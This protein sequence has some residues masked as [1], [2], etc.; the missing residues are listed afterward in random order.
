VRKTTLL[1]IPPEEQAQ[2]LAVLRRVRYGS[3]L[4]LHVLLLCA[5]GRT[6]TEIAA[7][8]FCSRSS[9]YRIVRA[10][11]AG[12]LVLLR[13][14][15]GQLVPPL[16]RSGLSVPLQQ[17]LVTMLATIPQTYGWC[18]TRWR[19]A[20]LALTL[21]AQPGV[22]V[23][24]ET[25]RR[26]LHA[27][28]WVWKRAK[29]IA[30]DNNPCRAERLAR[31]RWVWEHLQPWAA[32]VFADERDIHLV[33]KVGA[34]W[35]PKGTQVTVMTPGQN[36]KHSLAGALDVTTGTLWHCL[37]ARKTN[38]LFRDLLA[39]LE[40][41]YPAPRYRRLYIVVD[42]CTIHQAQAVGQW[43]AS[44]PRI[45]LLF[46]PPYCP[47][48]NPIERAFGDVHDKCTRN[49][50]RTHLEEL[51][52]DVEQHCQKN[53]PWCSQLSHLYYEP[54]VTTAMEALATEDLCQAAA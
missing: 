24:A 5:A 43:L 7:F 16:L 13:H 32:L 28:G 27:L 14:A 38:A 21:H 46:L 40:E 45:Q 4:A 54:E 34:M 49:H 10:Y 36:A 29:L 26:W 30:K 50:T 53:G 15:E 8:L 20:T 33:P 18:R 44:H 35:M 3:L 47:R 6:P 39:L 11:R 51:V 1:D 42:N 37:G 19:C 41:R 22:T 25:V 48:A 9:I 2:R 17:A 52:S 23:S 12:T 31:I